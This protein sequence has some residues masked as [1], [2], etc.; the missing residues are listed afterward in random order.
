MKNLTIKIIKVYQRL[1]FR[2]HSSCKYIPTCSNYAIDALNEYG[3]IK[4]SI[5]SI[6]RILKCNPLSKG[7][8]D[9]VKRRSL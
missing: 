6:K 9:I 3:F 7:G 1:P 5:M 8:I 4:G 2:S